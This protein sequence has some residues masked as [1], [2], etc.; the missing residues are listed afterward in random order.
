MTDD[1]PTK[2][3]SKSDYG[4]LVK[5]CAG[6]GVITVRDYYIVVLTVPS[7]KIKNFPTDLKARSLITT[8]T[9]LEPMS[10]WQLLTVWGI[11]HT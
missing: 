3:V 2:L 6:R 9:I 5:Q 10:W 7:W 8:L 11:K 1:L 4:K